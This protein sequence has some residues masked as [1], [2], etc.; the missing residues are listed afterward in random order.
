M[1]VIINADDFGISEIVT[2]EI[3][4]LI[5]K[6]IVTST[7]IL[8][9]GRCL[10]EVKRFTII[11]PEISY[12]AHLCLSEYSSITKSPILHKYGLTDEGGTFVHKAIFRINSFQDE[13]LVAI[14]DELIAQIRVLKDLGI[15]LSHSDSHHH[16][17]TI[18]ELRELFSQVFKQEGIT[19]VRIPSVKVNWRVKLHLYT[20]F[21]LLFVNRFYKSIFITTDEFSSFAG[22]VSNKIS[23]IETIELMC[24]P[25]HSS[26]KFKNEVSLIEKGRFNF[27]EKIELISYNDLY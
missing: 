9:N 5:E 8:A 25:G 2:S 3:E 16:V 17:H 26:Q 13:L 20:Y 11:H 22:F 14:K 21:K 7:T 6:R 15:P 23:N 27:D 24:H 10:D 18:Y 19:R 4:R 1:K 12:G